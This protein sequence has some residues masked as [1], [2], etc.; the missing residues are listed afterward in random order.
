MLC[1]SFLYYVFTRDPPHSFSM[2]KTSLSQKKIK[3]SFNNA[4]Y[5]ENEN[6]VV[7]SKSWKKSRMGIPKPGG[8][9]VVTGNN[10]SWRKRIALN[11]N[12]L[13]KYYYL[14]VT[15]PQLSM[16]PLLKSAMA[17]HS[18]V[19]REWVLH[20]EELGV[21]LKGTDTCVQSK[22]SLLT[23]ALGSQAANLQEK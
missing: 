9:F 16:A 1:F 21:I 18:L 20:L 5:N 13:W 11:I 22:P 6:T 10:N 4:K 7:I 3:K 12:F 8:D 15:S 2:S 23:L 17:M 14:Y 19:L